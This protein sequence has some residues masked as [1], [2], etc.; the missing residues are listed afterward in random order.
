MPLSRMAAL[1]FLILLSSTALWAQDPGDQLEE[2]SQQ[3]ANPIADLMSFPF[4]NNT[5]FGLGPVDRTSNVLKIQPVIPFAGG[6]IVTRTIFPFVWIPDITAESGLLASGLADIVFTAFYV[7]ESSITWGV[8]PVLEF[9]TGGEK[10]G[11]QKWSAGISGLILVQ[12]G[13]WTFGLLANN[14]WSFAGDSAAANV[15]K[16]LIQYFI[17]YQLG[18]GWY[19]NSAPTITVNWEAEDGQKWKVP[20]GAGAGKLLRVGKLPVN[21]QS[22]AYYFAVKPDIGP[23]WQ[24]RVQVQFLLPRPGSR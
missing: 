8:G 2:L 1:P 6:R 15:N 3:A 14:V 16:G 13:E 18:D 7:P 9:P 11:S 4:Q 22:Q 20:F 19:V 12:P 21:V 17:V 23:D 10:R 5:D 24:L